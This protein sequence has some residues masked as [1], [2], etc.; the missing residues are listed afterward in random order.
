MPFLKL[1]SESHRQE[2]AW[3]V[4]SQ[5]KFGIG[6][7]TDRHQEGACG[8]HPEDIIFRSYL[9]YGG[10]GIEVGYLSQ[11]HKKKGI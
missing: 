7:E 4:Q 10:A 6:V 1:A 2:Q 3:F 5:R 11:K 8:S 9:G